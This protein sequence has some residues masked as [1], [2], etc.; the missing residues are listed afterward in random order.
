M[1]K[2]F[3][4]EGQNLALAGKQIKRF[5]CSQTVK[6]RGAILAADGKRKMAKK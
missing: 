3:V 6:S 2:S 5:A 4:E 1:S